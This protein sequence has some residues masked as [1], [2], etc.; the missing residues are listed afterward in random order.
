MGGKDRQR[1]M[2]IW[3][4]RPLKVDRKT[5]GVL[6]VKDPVLGIA[7]GIQPARVTELVRDASAHDGLV[8]RFLWSYPDV[9]PADWSWDESDVDDLA[10]M[11]GFFR[12][13]RN[14]PGSIRPLVLQPEP[15][16]KA[17]WKD[18]YDATVKQRKTLPPLAK[19]FASK[20]PAQLARLWLVLA[21]LWEPDATHGFAPVGRL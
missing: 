8:Q 19:E 2:E 12:S 21:T 9:T 7:G 17:V 11:V 5:Q 15:A 13:L 16:A 20:H 3:N 1:F 6:F 18:W 10:W 14:P 4:G